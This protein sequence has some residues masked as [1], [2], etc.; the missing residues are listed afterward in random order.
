MDFIG[1]LLIGLV[2]GWLANTMVR[3]GSQGL[4][5]NLGIG[6]VGAFIGGFLFGLLGFATV[7]IIGR[8]ISAT[9]GAIVLLYLVGLWKKRNP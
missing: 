8:L 6:V 5:S 4:W 7:N 2:A 1:F 3:G 9:I